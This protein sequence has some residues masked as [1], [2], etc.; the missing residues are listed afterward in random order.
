MSPIFKFQPSVSDCVTF[1]RVIRGGK[2]KH[3]QFGAAEL[4]VVHYVEF[5]V[6]VFDFACSVYRKQA[7]RQHATDYEGECGQ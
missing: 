7:D 5:S 3:D 4:R 2:Y 6:G 1:V